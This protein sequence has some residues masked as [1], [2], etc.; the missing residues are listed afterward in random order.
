[1]NADRASVALDLL[2]ADRLEQAER[3]DAD[4]LRETLNRP[5]GEVALATFDAAHVGAVDPEHDGERL[6][7]ETLGLAVAAQVA[8]EN[9][10]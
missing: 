6:L 10:L 7:A 1:V 9:K 8:A 4:P 2:A 5:Q 3:L